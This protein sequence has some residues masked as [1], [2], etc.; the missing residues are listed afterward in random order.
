VSPE[1][2]LDKESVV[3]RFIKVVG[4]EEAKTGQFKQKRVENKRSLTSREDI[5]KKLASF[6]D[7][8][9]AISEEEE[10]VGNNNLEICFI[11]ETA[12]DDEDVTF[13]PLTED[14]ED[15]EEEETEKVLSSFPRSKSEGEALKTAHKGRTQADKN[16]RK[17]QSAARVALAQCKQVARRQLVIEKQIRSAENPLKKLLGVDNSE[18]TPDLLSGYNINTLQVILNDFREKIEQD[19][20][21][22][23]EQVM[24][25][26]ELQNEQDSM[27]IDIEDLSHSNIV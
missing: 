12:S 27:L 4:V 21:E 10:E 20:T 15:T 5:R 14:S 17:I 1:D 8:H 26:D 3:N 24:K 16:K 6:G 9:D 13:N 23:M 11:N 18:L 25:K 2:L 7:E 19:N 22:L